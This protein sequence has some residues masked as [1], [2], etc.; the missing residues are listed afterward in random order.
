MY[1]TYRAFVHCKNWLIKVVQRGKIITTGSEVKNTVEEKLGQ[2][3]HLHVAE[4]FTCHRNFDLALQH[5][6]FSLQH[7]IWW[8]LLYCIKKP[9]TS[10]RQLNSVIGWSLVY[11]CIFQ[12]LKHRQFCYICNFFQQN[13]RKHHFFFFFTVKDLISLEAVFYAG[14]HLTSYE[15]TGCPN[16][17]A[18]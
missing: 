10:S 14:I 1:P 11:S 7:E 13:K 3:R 18:I 5:S 2:S 6:Y 12:S 8:I 4:W 15:C 17:C 9:T 16:D